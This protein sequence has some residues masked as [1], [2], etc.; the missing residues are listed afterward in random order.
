[1]RT[2][3][4]LL[5]LPARRRS[6]ITVSRAGINEQCPCSHRRT[7]TPLLPTPLSR[8]PTAVAVCAIPAHISATSRVSSHQYPRTA[9]K[10]IPR[11][12]A[13]MT[14][15]PKTT[16]RTTLRRR[17]CQARDEARL[18]APADLESPGTSHR[19]E[20][21]AVCLRYHRMAQSA[22]S[23]PSLRRLVHHCH[24]RRAA[25]RRIR[26]ALAQAYHHLA[27]RFGA[28]SARRSSGISMTTVQADRVLSPALYIPR[29]HDRGVRANQ[30]RTCPG[31]FLHRHRCP[32][33]PGWTGAIASGAAGRVSQH[34]QIAQTGTLRIR[35][36][37]SRR[38]VRASRR[39]QTGRMGG[40]TR[41][42]H[43]HLSSSGSPR[44]SR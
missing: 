20:A 1:M 32:Q 5:L 11:T 36:R 43:K 34:S 14:S 33:Q 37:Q 2:A 10:D 23:L 6:T 30:V 27:V 31:I 8:I 15:T 7:R 42:S 40:T 41:S 24:A 4:T 38:M 13:S 29:S 19:Y 21:V 17:A 35:A 12:T 28:S 22:R 39:L 25:T 18:W 16:M 3:Q 26:V 9:L 44:T